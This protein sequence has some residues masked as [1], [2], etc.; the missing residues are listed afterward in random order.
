MTDKHEK[1]R[2][3]KPNDPGWSELADRA[4]HARAELARVSRER[5]GILTVVGLSWDF[6]RGQHGLH[7]TGDPARFGELPTE[8]DGFRVF[9]R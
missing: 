4:W 8:V 6:E 7:G 2:Q 3:A 1:R 9:L 5:G